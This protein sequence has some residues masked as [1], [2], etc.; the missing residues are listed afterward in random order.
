MSKLEKTPIH[1][2][3]VLAFSLASVSAFSGNLSLAEDTD[4]RIQGVANFLL[5]RANENYLYLFERKVQ[6]NRFV[7][8]YFPHTYETL[9]EN[10]FKVL[11]RNR[12]LWRTSVENDINN[13]QTTVVTDLLASKQIL[14]LGNRYWDLLR[15]LDM[16]NGGVSLSMKEVI[17]TK[18][19][20]L[21]SEETF[22]SPLDTLIEYGRHE[23]KPDELIGLFRIPSEKFSDE[24]LDQETTKIVA[25]TTKVVNALV[26]P[27]VLRDALIKH[28]EINESCISPDTGVAEETVFI[29]YPS[30]DT[31][32][33]L[34][35]DDVCSANGAKSPFWSDGSIKSVADFFACA[36][37]V[38]SITSK[39]FRTE[40]EKKPPSIKSNRVMDIVQ[41]G[42]IKK[43]VRVFLDS[44]DK[45]VAKLSTFRSGDETN[46]DSIS[47]IIDVIELFESKDTEILMTA[48]QYREIE[49]IIEEIKHVNEI[50][51][52]V[53]RDTEKSIE[54][55]IQRAVRKYAKED[56]FVR[57]TGEKLNVDVK[58]AIDATVQE[59]V[60]DN[61]ITYEQIRQIKKLKEI[62]EAV[63]RDEAIHGGVEEI[64]GEKIDEKIAEF[65]EDNQLRP[66]LDLTDNLKYEKG[67]LKLEIREKNLE[68]WKTRG[69]GF[70]KF[71]ELSEKA[72]INKTSSRSERVAEVLQLLAYEDDNGK[73]ILDLDREKF[74]QF[75]KYV[76]FFAEM[77]DAQ[78]P[79]EVETLLTE[80]TLP[81]VSYGTK[82]EDG[83]YELL[84]SAYLGVNASTPEGERDSKDT[85]GNLFAPL[86][87]EWVIWRDGKRSFSAMASVLDFAEPINIE[88]HES[89]ESVS[90]EDITVPGLYL[91]YGWKD[92][93]VVVGAGITE[94]S[95]SEDEDEKR[96]LLFIAFDMPLF[97]GF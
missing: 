45:F 56:Q 66:L 58:R 50:T 7:E 93:P 71:T 4:P 54:K 95:V 44:V 20:S 27:L 26:S 38:I 85:R 11:L 34:G 5:E 37:T 75:A 1:R 65:V 89:E 35:S 72:K 14:A 78:D 17:S 87:A 48:S 60:T 23:F 74:G 19:S 88:I 61:K 29:P 3:L 16:V 68:K 31:G 8:C 82:R 24:Q 22:R 52:E 79:K 28:R 47:R 9:Q 12:A 69:K 96:Y 32:I 2:K 90:L 49:G 25:Q 80:V 63:R 62:T 97:G 86:G 91:A 6:N 53:R 43:D 55:E 15:S 10:S 76:V 73:P 70:R 59:Y 41:L 33:A 46:D 64:V 57:G 84:V 42:D 21:P 18:R 77:S 39:T 67:V 81:P 40:I 51:E 30:I 92:I 13:I 36:D 83:G 94:G